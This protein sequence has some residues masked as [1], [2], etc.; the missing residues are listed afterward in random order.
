[1]ERPANRSYKL[2]GTRITAA[3]ESATDQFWSEFGISVDGV[4]HPDPVIPAEIFPDSQ[5]VIMEIG[6][7]MGEATAEIARTFPDVGFLAVELH[8]PGI[9]A[10]L[11]R[12]AEMKLQ[13]IRIIN[14]DARVVLE[15]LIPD[16][17]ISAFHLY[18]PDPWPKKKHWKRRIVQADFV[19]LISRKLQ[20]GGYIHIATDWVP[21][22]Q[23]IV[24]LFEKSDSFSGGAIEKPEFRPTTKFEGQGLRK[25]HE[26][27]DLKYFKS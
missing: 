2:R 11:A 17:S 8:R 19:E 20:P 21:Y 5:Q 14:D 18:F 12:I 16:Q 7:G 23:W 3:Q 22:A 13:N 24:N 15:N 1:M 10:L 25:G 26:V 4:E 27:T 9:G 6:T